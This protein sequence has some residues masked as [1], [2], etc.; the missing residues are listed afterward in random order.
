[1]GEFWS[2]ENKFPAGKPQTSCQKNREAE[3]KSE[4]A[5]EDGL[6]KEFAVTRTNGGASA[7]S[8]MLGRLSS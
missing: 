6:K 8:P 1:M 4:E 5:L 3:K 2:T 7:P